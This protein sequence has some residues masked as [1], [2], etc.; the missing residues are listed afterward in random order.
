MKGVPR[1]EVSRGERNHIGVH[2]RRNSTHDGTWHRCYATI[3][4][5]RPH[6]GA[7]NLMKRKMGH[8]TYVLLALSMKHVSSPTSENSPPSIGLAEV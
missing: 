1:V 4:L 5:I 6:R 3:R 8:D 2:R 7:L